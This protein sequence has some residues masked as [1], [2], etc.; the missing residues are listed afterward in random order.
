MAESKYDKYVIRRPKIKLG[1]NNFEQPERIPAKEPDTGPIVWEF[2]KAHF[3]FESGIISGDLIVGNGPPHSFSPHLHDYGEIFCFMGTNPKDPSDLGAEA[4]FW[5]GEGV[6]LDKV[7]INTTACV[8]VPGG[9]AHFPLKWT[10]VK[11]P[12]IF[13]VFVDRDWKPD[14]THFAVASME[15]RPT[16]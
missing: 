2:E 6:E 15:G 9:L 3:G 1:D 4:E 5:L 7:V 10:N 12:I 13:L 11:R 14:E 8:Y 16:S